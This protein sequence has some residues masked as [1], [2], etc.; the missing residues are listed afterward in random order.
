MNTF[1]VIAGALAVALMAASGLAA[2]TTGWV[3]P[4]GR[5]RVLR[6]KLRGYG[7]LLGAAAASLWMFLGVFPAR[8]DVLP[9]VA[10]VVFMG[11]LGIQMLA[12]R[13]GRTPVPPATKSVS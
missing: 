10:W 7:Q 6:P 2:V 13:P 12:Q 11:S 3:A 5:R 8:F 4:F 9:L 1:L